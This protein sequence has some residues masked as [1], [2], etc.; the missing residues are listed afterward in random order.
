M[1]SLRTMAD[2]PAAHAAGYEVGAR[3]S[4]LTYDGAEEAGASVER[5]R[6]GGR[7]SISDEHHGIL[8]AFR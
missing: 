6:H 4:A 3:A 5:G 2:P 8:L 1:N 7:P